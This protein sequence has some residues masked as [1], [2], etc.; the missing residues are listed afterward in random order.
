MAEQ[1]NIYIDQGVDFNL[2]FEV[3]DNSVE[4]N[5]DNY[6]FFASMG[7]LYS[8]SAAVDFTITKNGGMIQLSMPKEITYSLSPGK[9]LYDVIMVDTSN[10]NQTKIIGGIAFVLETITRTANT[11]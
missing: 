6:D 11:G 8:T 5:Y 2:E 9:Y 1:V 3:F 4:L 7:K 10:S